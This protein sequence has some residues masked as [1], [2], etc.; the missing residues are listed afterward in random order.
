[1][2]TVEQSVRDAVATTAANDTGESNPWPSR[3][4][5]WKEFSRRWHEMG[6]NIE[7]RYEDARDEQNANS[8]T[9]SSVL[10]GRKVNMFYSN[11]TVIKESLFNSLPK[12]VVSRLH[13][14]EWDNDVARV[15]AMIVQR[16]LTYEIKQAPNF[17]EAIKAAI[18]DRLVPGAG[19]TWVCFYPAVPEQRDG[20]G[21]IIR[22]GQ[23]EYIAVEITYWKDLLWEPRR[24]WEACN[25]VGRR[26]PY[27]YEDAKAKWG[28]EKARRLSPP[29]NKAPANTIESAI[30]HDDVIV[31]QMW[32]RQNRKVIHMGVDGYILDE[33]TDIYLLK[34]FYPTPK[35][36]IA[37][38]TTRSF[39]PLPDYYMAQ[40]QYSQLDQLYTRISLI[41]EAIK[42]AGVYDSSCT[43]VVRMLS[44][45][46]NKLIPVD[47]FA[48]LAEK[49]G[50]Q[51]VIDFYPVAEVATV[52]THLIST[53][54]FVK[55]QLF[56]GTGMADIVRGGSNQYETAA[57]Q[58]IKAQFA[59]V[60]LNGYQRDTATFVR[61]TLRIMAELVVQ[62][63]S[64]QRLSE[65]CGKL[66]DE[67]QQYVQPALQLLRN[68]FLMQCSIDIE[69][70]SLTQSDWGLEQQQ[71]MSYVQALGGFIQSALPTAQAVPALAPLLITII[72]FAS[73]GF[74]GSDELEG[75]LDS[76]LKMLSQ[77]APEKPDPEMEKAK[78]EMQ[79]AQAE[80]ELDQQERQQRMLFE[81][82]KQRNDLLFAREKHQQEMEQ[83]RQKFMLEMEQTRA[84][85][86]AQAQATLIKADAQA[87]AAANREANRSEET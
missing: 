27:S 49:G 83:S 77:P 51:G 40:D 62:L 39:L 32:D 61:G 70:D 26:I 20:N 68:D 73:V 64:D 57:A 28:E 53:Y 80:F 5:N 41:I 56:E 15:A 45:A 8:S 52:L 7:K 35:P 22:K 85:A 81:Q 48:M 25:W 76:A 59:S 24:N 38:P 84:K 55:Q 13:F 14:G 34:D 66:P 58:Q 12:P 74:K 69:A 2:S 19:S 37:S 16:A 82:E 1:M 30:E 10:G 60:R 78:M 42:V 44:G 47:N 33:S 72:K 63:Y 18:L 54:S 36:L 9:N 11:T 79:Q 17:S 86:G 4:N 23:P 29:N 43:E 21:V 50:I 75:S 46:E 31:I 3:L 65:V 87:E 67:D 71:R 6:C